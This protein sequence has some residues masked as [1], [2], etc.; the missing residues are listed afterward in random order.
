[1]FILL[2]QMIIMKTS[3]NV[4]KLLNILTSEREF[5]K[6]SQKLLHGSSGTDILLCCYNTILA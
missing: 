3:I 5:R 2:V 6:V 4:F 1:M